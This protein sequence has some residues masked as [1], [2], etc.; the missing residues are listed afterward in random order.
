MQCDR[1]VTLYMFTY[2]FVY[3]VYICLYMFMYISAAAAVHF[4]PCVGYRSPL[5]KCPDLFGRL[6]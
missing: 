5:K 3:T 1:K 4:F 2:V 6:F